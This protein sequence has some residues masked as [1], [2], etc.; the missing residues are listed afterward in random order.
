MRKNLAFTIAAVLT[1]ALAGVLLADGGRPYTVS[2]T[3][4]EEAPGPGDPDGSGTAVFHVN[5][6]RGELHFELT[7]SGIAAP[8]AA[9]IHEAP[10]GSPG[11]VVV[12][13]TAPTDGSS[14]G[15][16]SIDREVALELIQHPEEYYV[17]V[18]NAEYPAGAIRGQL[19]R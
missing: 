9:H 1:L 14:S 15:T 19:S 13:L 7:V 2:L 12:P 18:H 8:T 5:P 10:A 17:N 6:G 16:V 4:A 11:P 3:G